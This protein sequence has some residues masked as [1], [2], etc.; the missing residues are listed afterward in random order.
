[1]TVILLPLMI[2]VEKPL[3]VSRVKAPIYSL[4]IHPDGT[5]FATCQGRSN[6]YDHD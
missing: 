2:E 6:T 3:W 1:V 4:D 5:R